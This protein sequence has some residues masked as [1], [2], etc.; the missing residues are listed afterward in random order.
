MQPDV[1]WK[2]HTAKLLQEIAT[3]SGQP[4]LVKPLQIFGDILHAVGER[5]AQLNDPVLNALM[6]RLAIYEIGDPA[7]PK[8]DP[9]KLTE[10]YQLAED[11]KAK[12][13]AGG[14]FQQKEN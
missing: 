10:I 11:Q 14:V 9:V 3:N 2:V 5:A 13:T 6:C 8:F 7:S 1:Q 4:I 12:E